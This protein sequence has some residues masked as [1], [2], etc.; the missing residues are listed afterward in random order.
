[1]TIISRMLV[2]AAVLMLASASHLL[3][4]TRHTRASL[5]HGRF[6]LG[7][8]VFIILVSLGMLLGAAWLATL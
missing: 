7:T 2:G 4:R 1:M 8:G 3:W 5:P 6:V